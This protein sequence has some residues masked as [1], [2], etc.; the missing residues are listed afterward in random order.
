VPELRDRL[1]AWAAAHLRDEDLG[2]PLECHA[3][4]PLDQVT[5]ELFDCLRRLEPFGMGNEEPIFVARNVRILAP[6]QFMKEKHVRLRLAQ[7][8]A[9]SAVG[10]NL[11]TRIRDLRLGPDSVVH[12][13]YRLRHND[14]PEFG[15]LELEIAGIDS[16]QP[17]A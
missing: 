8:K 6:P 14:H 1:T 17:L 4:L 13:A 11:A 15:G 10:W 7:G 16:A 12:L 9:F 2:N 5:P 3:E